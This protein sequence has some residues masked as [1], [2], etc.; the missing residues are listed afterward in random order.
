M[1]G[2]L[3]IYIYPTNMDCLV[4]S[5]PVNLQKVLLHFQLLFDGSK[6]PGSLTMIAENVRRMIV[7]VFDYANTLKPIADILPEEKVSS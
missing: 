1:K 5:E 6:G 2:L 7:L 3:D 4:A